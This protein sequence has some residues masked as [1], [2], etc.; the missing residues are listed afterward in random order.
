MPIDVKICGI[1]NEEAM[2]AAVSFG[3]AYVGLVFFPPSPRAV[4]PERA[5]ELTEFL[6]EDIE[7]VGLFVNPDDRLLDAVLT[8]TRLDII[9]LHG[10]ES[11]ERLDAIRL[12][13]GLPVMKA[14]PISTAADLASAEHFFAAADSLLFDAKPPADATRPG[15]NAESFDWSLMAGRKWPLPW[16]LAGGLTPENVAEAVRVTGAR[17]VDVSSGVEDAAGVKNPLK[18]K[19]FLEAVAHL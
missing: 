9:Q 16:M 19:A 6:P 11:P 3:A 10:T 4:T 12:E 15:G 14:V 8:H 17:A 1:T 2:E 13:F 18:I 5:A 7:K